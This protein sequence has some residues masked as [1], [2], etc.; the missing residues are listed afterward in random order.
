M[1]IDIRLK[2]LLQDHG[3]DRHGVAQSM[4]TD[5][6][7]HRHTIGK[8]YRNQSENPSLEV[9]GQIC[10]WLI[11]KGV[12]AGE[13]P[14]GLFG[15]R[16]PALWHAIAQAGK[17]TIYLGERC[18]SASPVPATRWVAGS[19]ASVVFEF[20]RY[21]SSPEGS[22]DVRPGVDIRHIPFR[23]SK[24]GKQMKQPFEQDVNHA[25]NLFQAMQERRS[26]PIL[27]G[28]QKV[29]YL[30]ELYVADIFGQIAFQPSRR[31]NPAIPFYVKYRPE[32]LDLPSCFGGQSS[33]P[34]GKKAMPPGICYLDADGKWV[35]CPWEF[36]VR[37]A[38]VVLIRRD[39]GTAR[40]E[41]VVFGFSGRGTII[42]GERLVRDHQHFW[43]TPESDEEGPPPARDH[44]NREVAVF[45]CRFSYPDGAF[46]TE[47]SPHPVT[48]LEVIRIDNDMLQECLSAPR[49]R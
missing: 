45:I 47:V 49:E 19:D 28:S 43:F 26:N 36:D 44:A 46:D 10:E 27:V 42:A 14:H 6:N 32:D 40:M 30:V 21:L 20:V 1:K 23:Y 22:G 13:L 41:L 2:R 16:P 38:A 12:P 5:L 3:L 11:A 29:N 9:L 25:I 39:P 34:G 15:A 35:E 24:Q 31:V 8:L 37:D 18:Q 48:D 4:A 33:P 17:V 7:L